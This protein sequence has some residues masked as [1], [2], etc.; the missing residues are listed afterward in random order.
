M[1]GVVLAVGAS[2]AAATW[3]IVG[4]DPDGGEVGVA[5]ASCVAGDVLGDPEGPLVPVVIQPGIGA[6]VTQGQLNLDAPDRIRQLTRAAASPAEIVEDL[7][8]EEFDEVAEVRQHAVVSLEEGPAAFTGGE[9]SDASLDAQGRNVSV[10][11][12]LLVSDDVRPVD[13]RD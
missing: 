9:T 2:P 1:I 3:S 13:F 11:G 10:Q 12:N 8:T 7:V 6:A 5:I 4:T